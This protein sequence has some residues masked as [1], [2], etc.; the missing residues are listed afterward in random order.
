MANRPPAY[1]NDYMEVDRYYSQRINHGYEP[2]PPDA[3]GHTYEYA[4]GPQ[5]NTSSI[6]MNTYNRK[7]KYLCIMSLSLPYKSFKPTVFVKI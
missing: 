6:Q 3:T 1:N 7:S 5:A 4:N 2:P